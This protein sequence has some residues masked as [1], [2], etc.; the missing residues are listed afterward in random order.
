MMR[1]GVAALANENDIEN[2]LYRYGE[3]VDLARFDE[4]AD[5]FRHGAIR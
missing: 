2:L 4:L 1:E 5:L 3:Y